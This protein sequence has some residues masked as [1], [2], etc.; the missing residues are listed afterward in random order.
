[1]LRNSCYLELVVE[2]GGG[3]SSTPPAN[4]NIGILAEAISELEED[5]F[6]GSFTGPARSMFRYL[7][8]EM[9]F[10]GRLAFANLWLFQPVVTRMLLGDPSSA[11]MVRTTTL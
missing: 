11:S 10:G 9:S 1:M 7:G 6:P 2:G 5:P 4:T 8:P 3:H